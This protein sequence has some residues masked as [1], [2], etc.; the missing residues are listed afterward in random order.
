[1]TDKNLKV[2]MVKSIL[3]S[4]VGSLSSLVIPPKT[5]D[6]LVWLR[7]KFK[8]NSIQFQGKIQDPILDTNWLSVFARVSEETENPNQHMLPAPFDEELFEGAIIIMSSLSDNQETYEPLSSDYNDITVDHYES[9]YKEWIFD[10]DDDEEDVDEE[11]DEDEPELEPEPEVDIVKHE[12]RVILQQSENVFVDSPIRQKVVENFKELDENCAEEL[13]LSL[14]HFVTDMAICENI[15]IDWSNRVFW[16][17][18]RSKAIS[19]YENLR[20]N[21]YVGN[22]ENWLEKIKSGELTP[23]NFVDMSHIELF[24][25]RWKSTM[26]S[27]IEKEKVLY[28]KNDSASIF[29]WCSGCKKKSKC[30]YYQ[31]QTRSADEP[32]TTFVTCLECDKRWK[33]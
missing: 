17:M 27:L 4:Q 7:K 2:L 19:I 15:V 29:M 28:S 1:L 8:S 25:K 33:F 23:R 26:E 18:Y 10:N 30:D 20:G 22:S 32:M 31:L 12:T 14:L 13:E 11:E 3:I 6:V 21:G 16:N 9:L 24:P 5:P